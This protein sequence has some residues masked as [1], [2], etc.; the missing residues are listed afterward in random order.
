M[1]CDEETCDSSCWTRRIAILGGRRAGA[2]GP[3]VARLT[4]SPEPRKDASNH[5]DDA[6][7]STRPGSSPVPGLARVRRSDVVRAV[8]DPWCLLGVRGDG[9]SV[10]ALHWDPGGA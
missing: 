9:R 3:A 1:T 7:V 5:P 2:D 8:R 4:S 6:T 10:D